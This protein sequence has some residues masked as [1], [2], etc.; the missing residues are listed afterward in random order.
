MLNKIKM[1]N[2]G[3]K[4][5]LILLVVVFANCKKTG[6]DDVATGTPPA[7]SIE[8]VVFTSQTSAMVHI[9]STATN[10]EVSVKGHDG[11]EST[12]AGTKSPVSTPIPF[13]EIVEV[14]AR[15]ANGSS[16][17]SAYSASME[18]LATMN[19]DKGVNRKDM[20][21]T[22]NKARSEGFSCGGTS[23]PAVSKLVW[24]DKLEGLS[25]AYANDMFKNNATNGTGSD[26]KKFKDRLNDGGFTCQLYQ[27]IVIKGPS[28]WTD[29]MTAIMTNSG[30][31]KI[32]M[33]E[34]FK[35]L[36]GAHENGNWT[37]DFTE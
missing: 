35:F 24:D 18:V 2:K 19:V 27:E 7:P 37:I 13:G 25:I 28:S 31:C 11:V 34:N 26:G 14:K 29:I 36:A 15:A 32:V 33:S 30:S 16:E 22:I 9:N 8:K 12:H 6:D 5:L 1:K 3:Q 21:K 4:I 10:F 23:M 17:K 20:M